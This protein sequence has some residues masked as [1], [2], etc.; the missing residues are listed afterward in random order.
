MNTLPWNVPAKPVWLMPNTP[1][2]DVFKAFPSTPVPGTAVF[3]RGA[4]IL[5]G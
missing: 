2:L 5:Q 3:S 1:V 4:S